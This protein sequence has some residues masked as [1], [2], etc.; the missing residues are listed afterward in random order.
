[1]YPS[2]EGIRSQL[3][4][5]STLNTAHAPVPT[6]QTKFLRKVR[7]KVNSVEKLAELRLAGVNVVRMNFSHGSYEYHQSV[8]DN[9]RK[10]VAA[11]PNGRPVAIAL[12]TKGPEIR[13]GLTKNNTD[14]PVSA[15]HEFIISTDPKYSE[16]CDDKIVWVDYPN[17]ALSSQQNLPK[18]TAPGKLIYVDDGILS[19][20][21]LSI[22]GTNVHVRTLNSGN[23]SSRKGVNLPKTDVDLPALSE[24]D[25]A[26]LQFGVKNGVDMIFASFIRRGQDIRDIRTVL[27]PDG[28]NVK[29]IAKVENEQGVQN[30]DEILRETDGVMVARGDLGIEI[31]ASQVFLAQK[32]MIAKC[33]IVGKPVIVATQMLESMT[34]NP[35]PTRAEVSDVANAVL[36]GADCVML[37]GETAK[38]LYPIQSVLMMAE[39]CLLAE[40]AI[41]YPPLY[42]ELKS[43]QKRPTETPETVAIAAVAAAAEQNAS[44][45]LVLSTS[46]NTARLVSKYRPRVPILTVTRNEQTAR[47]IHLHR[48]CYPFWYPEPRGIQTHQWQTDVDNRIR[49]GL[50]NALALGVITPGS[51]VIAVQGWKG[52][53][54]HTNTLRILTVPTDP[55]DLELHIARFGRSAGSA[56]LCIG[57]FLLVFITFALAKRFGT[58]AKK[59]PRPFIG[60]P[61]T[62][63]FE[64][65]DLQ[66]IWNWEIASGHYPSRRP[67]P[68]EI[69]FRVVPRNPAIPAKRTVTRGPLGFANSTR[70]VGANRTYLEVKHKPGN[71][72][73]PP[74][75]VPGSVADLDVVMENCDF[76]EK[77]YVRDCLEVLRI[78]GGLDTGNRL[79]RGPLDDWKYIYTEDADSGPSIPSYDHTPTH[80]DSKIDDNVTQGNLR[81]SNMEKP[82]IALPSPLHHKPYASLSDPCDPDNPRMFHMFWTGPFTDKPYTA[83]LSFL[84]TQNIGLH[85]KTP[86]NTIC[87]PQ[88]WMWINPGPAASVPNPSAV[89]DMYTEL[90]QNPWASPFLHPRFKDIVVFKL[91]NTTEQ[92]DGVPELEDEWRKRDLFNS[93]GNIFAVPQGNKPKV[94]EGGTA[95]Q[96][97]PNN[98]LNRAG[99]KSSSTYDRMSVI[100]SDMARFVLCHRFGGTYLDADT[101]FLRDWEELWGWKGAFAYRWSRLP[102]YNTAVLHMNKHSALGTFLFRTALK[103]D[104]D[105]HP[106]TISRYTQDAHLE[107]LLLRLPDALFDSAWL[108]TENYQRDRPPQPYFTE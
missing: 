61:S 88:F 24:K 50:R 17:S 36:D 47:Q 26:D 71:T 91:W 37:S 48:G 13:T 35:R 30:F 96:V 63:V 9:T 39:T 49:F 40:S 46:G 31:P 15:G 105:F 29:I 102:R 52:G 79:R 7:P 6:E 72:A 68:E 55:A 90:K 65:E 80:P 5:N 92:L 75:P 21:V 77:K 78:G 64:R 34:Y 32:M 51:T 14:F 93:G 25:K 18:V 107:E 62:L 57:F 56:V 23:I 99:S 19:L 45:I 22:D 10:M 58:K 44:A 3:E 28:A 89:R 95:T 69:G 86:D 74:R 11:D 83:I 1:M 33:N 2:D 101:L 41:C 8:I 94:E 76:S 38:G 98:M 27:G 84:Y 82:P 53:L 20:L 66:R 59:W 81:S 12:D 103:N 87:R 42:D 54:G 43:I 108:N 4:W 16:S 97:D 85:L 100:L 106:M 70:G 104:L 67:I 73:Y 60:D